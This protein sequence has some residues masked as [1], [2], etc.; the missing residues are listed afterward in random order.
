ALQ[1]R[2]SFDLLSAPTVRVKSGEDAK[3]TV[4]RTF[5]FPT[6]YQPP[7]TVRFVPVA[8]F[9]TVNVPVKPPAVIPAFPT[10]FEPRDIGVKL[11]ARPFVSVDGKTID[12]ALAPEVT[13]LEGFINYGDPVFITSE[14]QQA[15]I[16]RNEISQPVF[17]TRRVNTRVLVRDGFTVV[18]G[19]LLR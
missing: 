11:S 6:A 18:L 9:G 15:L 17:N 12:L 3:I 13:D 19:G 4:G 7:D 1:Q 16:T 8:R 5:Y 2:K 10:D 14:G